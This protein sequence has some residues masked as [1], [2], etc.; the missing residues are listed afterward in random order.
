[1]A[2]PNRTC[3]VCK[4]SSRK[5]GKSQF[6]DVS[7]K[8]YSGLRTHLKI[9]HNVVVEK[10]MCLKDLV[11]YQ[12]E[13]KKCANRCC[14]NLPPI[15]K[16]K[17]KI[18]CPDCDSSGFV[19]GSGSKD[20]KKLREQSEKTTHPVLKTI[21][22]THSRCVVC[23]HRVKTGC[24]TIPKDAQI[25]FLIRYQT[26]IPDGSRICK[27][28]LIGKHLKIDIKPLSMEKNEMSNEKLQQALSLLLSQRDTKTSPINFDGEMNYHTWT[29][30]VLLLLCKKNHMSYLI[31]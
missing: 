1:M 26:L 14:Q 2:D 17:V 6:Q 9:T 19:S 5:I 10:C 12:R 18:S 24:T 8:L 7:A 21:G 31:C 15:E 4:I 3:D 20:A 22:S 30:S 13:M 25:D 23:R 11:K 27:K 16:G 29:G 28:H